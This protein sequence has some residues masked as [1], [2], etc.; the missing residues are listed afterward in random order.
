MNMLLEAPT[1]EAED[2]MV[3]V[4][5]AG[6]DST[7]NEPP[8]RQNGEMLSIYFSPFIKR[9]GAPLFSQRSSF[10]V[11]DLSLTQQFRSQHI[12]PFYDFFSLIIIT[13]LCSHSIHF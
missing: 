9:P 1:K 4:E 10:I 3:H 2:N 12:K 8:S 6:P 5:V 11:P 13:L 7:R